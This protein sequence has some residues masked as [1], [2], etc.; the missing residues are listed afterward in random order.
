MALTAGLTLSCTTANCVGGLAKLWLANSQDIDTTVGT[1]GF[2]AG[3]TGIYTGVTMQPLKYFWEFEYQ[4]FTGEFREN[5]APTENG[6]AQVVT[7]ELEVTFPCNTV[8]QRN[9]LQEIFSAVCC[10]LVAIVEKFDGTK[11]V[12]GELDKRHLKLLSTTGTSGKAL[13]DSQQT[14]LVLQAITTELASKF[15]GT[16]PV[17]P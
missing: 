4:D 2:T 11:W 13:S 9:A 10:G 16:P 1:Q 17:K 8:D 6:C 5:A 7:Q 14:V 15:T 12:I 3:T